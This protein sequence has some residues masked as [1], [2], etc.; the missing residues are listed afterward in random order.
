MGKFEEIL[1]SF[2]P[3]DS[4]LGEEIDNVQKKQ[5]AI[6]NKVDEKFEEYDEKNEDFETSIRVLHDD[7]SDMTFSSGKY[8]TNN[9]DRALFLAYQFTKDRCTD[10]RLFQVSIIYNQKNYWT[11]YVTYK[12]DSAVTVLSHESSE[13]FP[14]ITWGRDGTIQLVCNGETGVEGELLYGALPYLVYYGII[15]LA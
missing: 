2:T 5:E 3:A 1:N 14:K 11:G 6:E 13:N 9:P 10:Y 4:F 12:K 15:A 7:I 8:F